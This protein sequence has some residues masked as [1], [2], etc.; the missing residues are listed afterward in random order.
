MG[1]LLTSKSRKSDP[2]YFRVGSVV[3]QIPPESI[4][5]NRDSNNQEITTLRSSTPYYKKTGHQRLDVAVTWKAMIVSDGETKD[6]QQWRDV[7]TVL[8]YLK[9]AP[10]IEVENAHI[11]QFVMTE[12]L[13]YGETDRM[14]FAI[15][16]MKIET[17]PDLADCLEVS[18]FLSWFN[19]LPY[20]LNFAYAGPGG[21]EVSAQ[22]SI[23][24]QAY[25]DQWMRPNLP[26]NNAW[27]NQSDQ[28]LV[29]T[30]R[31]YKTVQ[32]PTDIVQDG[33]GVDINAKSVVTT[34]DAST[35]PDVKG[36]PVPTNRKA[37]LALMADYAVY[38]ER[39]TPGPV[40]MPAEFAVAQRIAEQGWTAAPNNN[41]FGIKDFKTDPGGT[42][43]IYRHYASEQDSFV[44]HAAFLLKN[45]RYKPAWNAYVSS[46]HDIPAQEQLAAGVMSAGYTEAAN[47]AANQK[48]KNVISLLRS[49]DVQQAVADARKKAGIQPASKSAIT[50]ATT[51]TPAPKNQAPAPAA[52]QSSQSPNNIHRDAV[53]QGVIDDANQGG[54]YLD[55][56]TESDMFFFAPQQI[57]LYSSKF[58]RDKYSDSDEDTVTSHIA[59][60][61]QNNIAQLPLDGSIFPTMQHV[62]SPGSLVNITFTAVGE[63]NTDDDE[64]VYEDVIRL[65]NMMAK[66]ESQYQDMRGRWRAVTS[67]HKMQAA[68]IRNKVLNML[69]IDYVMPHRLSSETVPD[70]PNLLQV[71]LSCSQ[72][73]NR[74]E[75]VNGFLVKD[76]SDKAIKTVSDVINGNSWNKVPKSV[77]DTDLKVL[78][79]FR[80]RSDPSR[81]NGPD[82]T[83]LTSAVAD[84]WTP[85]ATPFNF[86]PAD[87]QYGNLRALAAKVS[88][89]IVNSGVGSQIVVSALL[90]GQPGTPNTLS[91]DQ[92]GLSNRLQHGTFDY[93]DYIT[94]MAMPIDQSLK[95]QFAQE[96]T[97]DINA[98]IAASGKANANLTPGMPWSNPFFSLRDQVL[99]YNFENDAQWNN[100]MQTLS[101]QKDVRET[102]FTAAETPSQDQENSA[103]LCYT[104]LGIKQMNTDPDTYFVD[105]S[106][107]M[108]S[109]L[110]SQISQFARIAAASNDDLKSVHKQ[111]GDASSAQA[112]AKA[113]NASQASTAEAQQ[114]LDDYG[115]VLLGKI[116]PPQI[117]MSCAFPTYKVMLIEEDNDGPFYCFDDFYTYNSILNI[118]VGKYGDKP[119][120][121]RIQLTNFSNILSHKFYNGTTLNKIEEQDHNHEETSVP[122]ITDAD[123]NVM[124]AVNPEA[125]NQKMRGYKNRRTGTNHFE[126]LGSHLMMP[127]WYYSL[128]SGSKIQI[129]LGYSNDPDKLWPVF[130]GV[131]AEIEEGD[132]M[133]LHCQGYMVELVDEVSPND[134]DTKHDGKFQFYQTINGEVDKVLATMIQGPFAKHF[135]TR[136]VFRGKA[137]ILAN[138]DYHP[139]TAVARD[140]APATSQLSA[141]AGAV[142][143]Y[144]SNR[145]SRATENLWINRFL[146]TS[147]EKSPSQQINNRIAVRDWYFTA[148]TELDFSAGSF[149]VPKDVPHLTPWK[150]MKCASRFWPE[151]K[152][153]VR[154]YGFPYQAD[155]TLVFADP[156]DCFYNRP[157]LAS[158]GSGI[159]SYTP[160]MD[161][162]FQKWWTS[163]GKDTLN[164]ILQQ[165]NR[166]QNRQLFMSSY[167][168][169]LYDMTTGNSG[170]LTGEDTA[171]KA[172]QDSV[173]DVT[174]F[175][176]LMRNAWRIYQYAK[177]EADPGNNWFTNFWVTT[178]GVIQNVHDW[179]FPQRQKWYAI[180]EAI[181][182]L[183]KSFRAFTCF[184]NN[185]QTR[186]DAG[187][188]MMPV[189]KWHIVTTN[190]IISNG[191]SLNEKLYNVVRIDTKGVGNTPEILKANGN[192]PDEEL[193]LLDVT[194]EIIAP[195]KNL[196]NGSNLW[197]LQAQSFLKD[198]IGKM[199]RGD[200]VILGRPEIEVGDVV[201]IIDTV[202]D[203]FG[204]VEVDSVIHSLDSRDGMITII[205]PKALVLVN[206]ATGA[207]I[208]YAVSQFYFGTGSWF[209]NTGVAGNISGFVAGVGDMSTGG[210][211]SGGVSALLGAAT[212]SY[213]V[214]AGIR[215]AKGAGV[216][217]AKNVAPKVIGAAATKA[218]GAG[219]ACLVPG[220]NVIMIGWASYELA[221][222]AISLAL[223][224]A[225][226]HPL[227]ISPL[228]RY[229]RPW[230]A[231]VARWS[232]GNMGYTI[233]QKWQRAFDQEWTTNIEGI[234]NLIQDSYANSQ[235]LKAPNADVNAAQGSS[236]LLTGLAGTVKP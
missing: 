114:T 165:L 157:R 112:A 71:Q 126:T 37:F 186:W 231:G 97:K 82:I 201:H 17:V 208:N 223:A 154:N 179:A 40:G 149:T 120:Y 137:D 189:Q 78:A 175:Q 86:N 109:T 176:T 140:L 25:I 169:M 55:H 116:K 224:N 68:Q 28:E 225:D 90:T 212:S 92:S 23:A 146:V 98:A 52:T 51:P 63:Q 206:Q 3:L 203:I 72:Y 30:W 85:P 181:M 163:V 138:L 204:P 141:T 34:G 119:D 209:Q 56:Q 196:S 91:K 111:G 32:F 180:S 155:A 215:F 2:G 187:A 41:G 83:L 9:C 61:F 228:T 5:I 159:G 214:A 35:I 31:K 213:G 185:P 128:R 47:G 164:G 129:R 29:M 27:E 100:A 95:N 8:A 14:A 102:V 42:K 45:S 96:V 81:A 118:E 220:V 211:V 21:M 53:T 94:V 49:K 16:S 4:T 88:Q 24:F 50:P 143:S 148:P 22:D 133:T 1:L 234:K 44:D 73:K 60:V 99:Q 117:S 89:G 36:T 162:S 151:Y 235:D 229:N 33:A 130:N 202:R 132:I 177:G 76:P 221:H 222:G 74:Y 195:E 210:K 158:E 65:N 79:D 199:Y 121:A 124:M 26:A 156:G 66:L 139:L 62:G 198:E 125:D 11:R 166:Q 190:H 217:V 153:Q 161:T 113:G 64:P 70:S 178:R 93:A 131:V 38:A 170:V 127:S 122:Y 80:T 192:I 107:K 188:A 218:V 219:V 142:M 104:D 194:E 87:P 58:R 135:G 19:Y 226:M 46:A 20:T 171:I 184:F 13:G 136:Q 39:N 174:S 227:F 59:V 48:L 43:N 147:G 207:G 236:G 10:F 152:L 84:G 144:L 145:K 173:K 108:R 216:A 67:I 160:Q 232:M 105:Y 106:E 115:T 168:F 193:R 15:R 75:V 110:V 12:E 101:V 167:L 54:W 182:A 134:L 77:R 6:Y 57:D 183:D 123:G 103:H 172:I 233:T 205:R 200:L 197:R 7:R 150:V 18:L 69:G 191:I 230:M